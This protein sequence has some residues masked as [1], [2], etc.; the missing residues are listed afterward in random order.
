MT[1]DS[2]NS[3][4]LLNIDS[5]VR[6]FR[7]GMEGQG[8][9]TLTSLID[10][11]GKLMTSAPQETLRQLNPL[12]TEAMNAMA[13][14]DYLWAADLF[15]Y[16]IA[17]LIAPL[18]EDVSGTLEASLST[19]NVDGEKQIELSINGTLYRLKEH[20]FWKEFCNGW[21][22]ETL[23]LYRRFLP[24]CLKYVDVGSWI[25]PTLIYAH[26]AGATT[27]YAIEAN[28]KSAEMLVQ[29]CQLN[30]SLGA[31][32]QSVDNLCISDCNEMI[33]FGT[34]NGS[35]VTSSASSIRGHGFTVQ[36][37]K[38]LDYLEGIN[39]LQDAF[40]KIDIEG[41]ELS[42]VDDLT[43]VSSDY[44]EIALFL[45]LHP[46]FWD[47]SDK[48]EKLLACLAGFQVYS[49]SMNPISHPQLREMCLTRE[50]KPAWGTPFGNFFEVLVI[51]KCSHR[52]DD[53]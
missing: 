5:V 10:S 51:P 45:S 53:I 36:G 35:A 23:E 52:F 30:P 14:K 38:L 8:N 34:L 22:L 2:N 44:P 32:A 37:I 28:P 46:P 9:E 15:E 13:R 4:V 40:I 1:A 33:S 3:P 48:V 29:N 11:L 27:A 49:V 12:L 21:E 6:A 31:M 47:N 41:A 50:E 18:V 42:I 24:V 39:A 43:R 7:L 19:I 20:W 25:G 16:E 26:L 17:P